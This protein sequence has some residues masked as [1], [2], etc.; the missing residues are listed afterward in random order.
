MIRRR[1]LRESELSVNEFIQNATLDQLIDFVNINGFKITELAS[2]KFED[3]IRGELRDS[4]LFDF[5]LKVKELE[6][7]NDSLAVFN[8][9]TGDWTIMKC[10]DKAINVWKKVAKY[11]IKTVKNIKF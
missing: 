8:R 2:E 6:V 10:E 3:F 4:K 9:R 7:G 5:I 11:I 1:Y